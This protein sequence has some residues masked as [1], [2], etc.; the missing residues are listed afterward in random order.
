MHQDQYPNPAPEQ[1][2]WLEPAEEFA[3]VE[4]LRSGGSPVV[5]EYPPTRQTRFG[6]AYGPETPGRQ[7][8]GITLTDA[9]QRHAALDIVGRHLGSGTSHPEI[10]VT[11]T[12]TLDE[13]PT[14]VSIILS[15]NDGD[16]RDELPESR[17]RFAVIGESKDAIT[18]PQQLS[19]DGKTLTIDGETINIEGFHLLPKVEANPDPRHTKRSGLAMS[20]LLKVFRRGRSTTATPV[21]KLPQATTP[22]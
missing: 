9:D 3:A 11:G 17:T 22:R 13:Q 14:P 19:E 16:Y 10:V 2:H 21:V 18:R 1:R 4:Q 6:Q 7:I 12:R 20:G 15:H 8:D 5:V